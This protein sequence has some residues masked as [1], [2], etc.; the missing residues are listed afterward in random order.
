MQCEEWHQQQFH[1]KILNKKN[2]KILILLVFLFI[3]LKD[4]VDD[5]RMASIEHKIINL[6]LKIFYLILYKI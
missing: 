5:I 3:G 6:Y 4:G 1:F 2:H